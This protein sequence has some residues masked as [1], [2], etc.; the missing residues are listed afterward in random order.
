[1]MKC[2]THWYVHLCCSLKKLK[3]KNLQKGFHCFCD[4]LPA[5]CD[6]LLVIAVVDGSVLVIRDCGLFSFRVH[7]NFATID[8][9]V[10]QNHSPTGDALCASFH[11]NCM[12][13]AACD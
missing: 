7:A 8:R 1:M 6:L 11:V 13:T 10:L 4:K 5:V 12:L 9:A 3:I 2:Y